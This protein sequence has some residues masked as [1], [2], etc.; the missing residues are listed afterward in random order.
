MKKTKTVG[1][2]THHREIS[3]EMR[4]G[5]RGVGGGG[6]TRGG[7]GVGGGGVSPPLSRDTEGVGGWGGGGGGEGGRL[8]GEDVVGCH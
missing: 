2:C 4:R 5:G 1:V 8:G 7:G 3:V 6:V